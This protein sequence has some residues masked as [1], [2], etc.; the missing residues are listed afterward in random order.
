MFQLLLTASRLPGKQEVAYKCNKWM[1]VKI[2]PE[3]RR[4]WFILLPSITPFLQ[5]VLGSGQ[6]YLLHFKKDI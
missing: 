5:K 1:N 6:D 4:F 2:Y 3:Y